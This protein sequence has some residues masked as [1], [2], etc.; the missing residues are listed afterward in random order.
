[1]GQPLVLT[2]LFIPYQIVRFAID[3][4]AVVYALPLVLFWSTFGTRFAAMTRFIRGPHSTIGRILY[5]LPKMLLLALGAFLTVAHGLLPGWALYRILPLIPRFRLFYGLAGIGLWAAM[6]V[7]GYTQRE[8]VFRSFPPAYFE[9]LADAFVE[10]VTATVTTIAFCG[11]FQIPALLNPPWTELPV[12]T[13]AAYLSW[14]WPQLWLTVLDYIALVLSP[15]FLLAPW[16]LGDF[17]VGRREIQAGRQKKID[18]SFAIRSILLHSAEEAILDA[19][20]V[21]LA[22]PVALTLWRLPSLIRRIRAF[23][24]APPPRPGASPRPGQVRPAASSKSC[25]VL[26]KRHSGLIS[27]KDLV[28]WDESR[29]SLL[30]RSLWMAFIDGTLGLA[31]SLL[32]CL[33]V[34]ATAFRIPAAFKGIR[35]ALTDRRVAAETRKA[36]VRLLETAGANDATRLANL[37]G[38]TAAASSIVYRL[39]SVLMDPACVGSPMPWSAQVV[40]PVVFE[41]AWRALVDLPFALM[42][43][44]TLGLLLIDPFCF[45]LGA[46][47]VLTGW[48]APTLLQAIKDRA[49]RLIDEAPL[50]QLTAAR[51]TFNPNLTITIAGTKPAALEVPQAQLMLLMS[52]EVRAASCCPHTAIPS[53]RALPILRLR[54]DALWSDP[55]RAMTAAVHAA[56][57]QACTD[58]PGLLR[59]RQ[60]KTALR[61]QS[62]VLPL[63]RQTFGRVVAINPSMLLH[64]HTHG[65]SSAGAPLRGVLLSICIKPADIDRA[66]VTGLPLDFVNLYDKKHPAYA[67]YRPILDARIGGGSP[68][69]DRH[70]TSCASSSHHTTAI[71]PQ[72]SHHI[73]HHTSHITHPRTYDF[74]AGMMQ[75]FWLLLDLAALA[76]SLL[77]LAVS[78]L[79]AILLLRHSLAARRQCDSLQERVLANPHVSH[80]SAGMRGI[81]FL[82]ALAA[83]LDLVAAGCA[84]LVA[85]TWRCR[86]LGHKLAQTYPR[87]GND[88]STRPHPVLPGELGLSM[89]AAALHELIGLLIDLP[90]VALFPALLWRIP[91]TARQLRYAAYDDALQ[92][93]RAARQVGAYYRAMAS[94]SQ[95]ALLEPIPMHRITGS[96][97]HSNQ[98]N[99]TSTQRHK[100]G[101]IRQ[102]PLK[103]VFLGDQ[104]TSGGSQKIY[105]TGLPSAPAQ[106]ASQGLGLV[107]YRRHVVALAAVNM[108]FDLPAL[109]AILW[110][111]CCCWR[112]GELH[113]PILSSPPSPSPQLVRGLRS[114]MTASQRCDP[115]K[116]RAQEFID[117]L[118][119]IESDLALQMTATEGQAEGRWDP[120]SLSI[121]AIQDPRLVSNAM[122]LAQAGDATLAGH[123]GLKGSKESTNP[124]LSR[125]MSRNRHFL[126]KTPPTLSEPHLHLVRKHHPSV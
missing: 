119:R 20:H 14:A 77:C 83:P 106:P 76:A 96:T 45:A 114:E 10:A 104:V 103:P 41:Q 94:G 66:C 74:P 15:L 71:T 55:G 67:T 44:I 28:N 24:P 52:Q 16:R 87:F 112:W 97:H 5:F 2:L 78:P 17:L 120:A 88:P 61:P 108:L 35:A 34:L 116:A 32:C 63:G 93:N 95:R 100:G 126:Q 8:F 80:H 101:L 62:N 46:L 29:A 4:G 33:I 21:V 26:A 36:Q 49:V 98:A 30:R 102:C 81:C 50:V 58:L 40:L 53:A 75:F 90:F 37:L 109:P 72:P 79:R 84:L 118:G 115:T 123:R 111:C 124:P 48:R 122:S 57:G 43:V 60:G 27:K 121:Y 18:K 70:T 69:P 82:H 105:G 6:V 22:L 125:Q 9:C 89:H 47:V 31:A 113:H 92:A 19:V 91:G 7:R 99:R 65:A 110:D 117:T 42:A 51:A 13:P 1:M 39:R 86:R 107:A 73:T 54:L 23:V 56:A 3:F 59:L 68:A 85:P 11:L 38:C 12:G 25:R 64:M